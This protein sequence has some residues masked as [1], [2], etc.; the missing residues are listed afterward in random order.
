MERIILAGT[1][2]GKGSEGIYCFRDNDGYL[3][4]CDLYY[5]IRNPKYLAKEGPWIAAAADFDNGS[6]IALFDRN[7]TLCDTAVYEPETSCYIT[8]QD[9]VIYTANY[10]GGT[11]TRACIRDGK[12]ED[13]KTTLI[14]EK[15]GCHQVL[16]WQ[17]L[18]LVP[19]LLLDRIMIYGQDLEKKGEIVFERGTGPRHG[20]FTEDGRWLYLASELSNEFFVIEAGTWRIAENI[21]VLMNGKMHVTGG[22]AVRMSKDEKTVY[23]STREEEVLSVIRVE[24]GKAELI[25]NVSCGGRHPRDFILA[26][27]HLL[28]A[29]RFTND[30][31]SFA[32]N[33]DGTIGEVISRITV[34]EAVSLLITDGET[35]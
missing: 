3:S 29:N 32:L 24:N 14:R 28:A 34:P 33:E 11:F 21:P 19:C 12:I 15:A 27:D 31:V 4:S 1:Y 35:K 10:H 26:G 18:I 7:G 13:V 20:V 8:I 16:L 22:A 6:G 9:N 2:T 30:V 5:R 23:V 17:D 25:Q